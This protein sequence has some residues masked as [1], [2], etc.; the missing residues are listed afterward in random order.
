MFTKL[1]TKS[2]SAEFSRRPFPAA[3]RCK[4]GTTHVFLQFTKKARRASRFAV[5]GRAR[6]DNLPPVD[7]GFP[8]PP[9]LLKPKKKKKK[10]KPPNPRRLSEAAHLFGLD[11][12]FP[13]R[14]PTH[15]T[16]Q[17]HQVWK[18]LV[19]SKRGSAFFGQPPMDPAKRNIFCNE[20]FCYKAFFF[21]FSDWVGWV[22]G[23]DHRQKILAGFSAVVSVLPVSPSP[24]S[25][26]GGLSGHPSGRRDNKGERDFRFGEKGKKAEGLAGMDSRL[27]G[28]GA[29][30]M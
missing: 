17:F 4:S 25:N 27:C 5:W 9:I 14:P 18:A 24:R 30:E 6:N 26:K 7:R 16:P 13:G 29:S 8:K 1:D 12:F 20:L 19:N 28:I 21:F 23:S 11:F 3:G 10:K 22:W 15:P 2:K